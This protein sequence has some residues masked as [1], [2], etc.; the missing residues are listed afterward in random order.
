MPVVDQLLGKVKEVQPEVD[1]RT[2]A[3]FLVDEHMGFVK[4]P[5]SWPRDHD[6]Q[7]RVGAQEVFPA[8]DFGGQDAARGV[9]KVEQGIDDVAPLGT[10]GVL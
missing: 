10:A 8:V 4:M 7:R 1:Q 2:H 6:S 5:A 9:P 3:A